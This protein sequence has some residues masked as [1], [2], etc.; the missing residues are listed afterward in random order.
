MLELITVQHTLNELAEKNLI[1]PAK[2]SSWNKQFQSLLSKRIIPGMLYLDGSM[3]FFVR[4]W[5]LM[6]NWEFSD[7]GNSRRIAVYPQDGDMS[8]APV[9]SIA[10]TLFILLNVALRS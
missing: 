6:T 1:A 9:D 2:L 5:N 3:I 10:C 4:T 7:L 8:R